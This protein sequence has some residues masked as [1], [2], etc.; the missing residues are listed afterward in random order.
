MWQIMIAFYLGLLLTSQVYGDSFEKERD[1]LIKRFDKLIVPEVESTIAKPGDNLQG[2]LAWNKS[3]YLA[4]IVEMLDATRDPK[5][6]ESFIK[7]GRWMADA[8]DDQHGRRDVFRKRVVPAWGSTKYTKGK[9]YAYAVHTGV[10]AAPMARFAAIV[11]ADESLSKR[12]RH[13]ADRFFEVARQAA[14]VHENQRREGPNAG[15]GYLFGLFVE[16]C[17]PLNQ[18]NAL[19]CVWAYL[20]DAVEVKQYGEWTLRLAHFLKN[21]LRKTEDGAYVWSY[22][23]TPDGQFKGF[24]DVSHAAINV[25]FMVMCFERRILFT[26][27]DMVCLEKTLLT[28]ILRDDHSAADT[29]GGTGDTGKYTAGVLR[30]GRLAKYRKSV[31]DRLLKFYRAG[32]FDN[33]HSEAL[34]IAYLVSAMGSERVEPFKVK[35]ELKYKYRLVNVLVKSVPELLATYD[36]GTGRFGK[37]IWICTDQNRMYPLAVAYAYSSPNN[38]Y[39]K[40]SKLLDVIM[41]AGDALIDDADERGQWVFRKKDGSTWGSIWMPWTYSRWVRSYLLIGD[42]MPANRRE[43]WIKALRL[44]YTGIS[45][46]QLKHVH[47]I[48]AHHAMGLY[49]AGKAL[50]RPDWCEQASAFFG[51]VIDSQADGGYWS[52]NVGPVVGY[53]FV[54]LDVLGTYYAM[55]GDERALAGLKKG[56]RFHYHF[57]YPNG[58]RVET[59]DERNPY[60]AGIDTGNVGFT[61]TS[62]GRAYLAEQWARYGWD[63]LNPDLIASL[64]L[65]GHEG[66]I[67]NLQSEDSDQLFVL[68]ERRSNKAATIRHGPWFVCLS[69]Y[70]APISKSRWIQ[71][72]QNLV[73][74]YHDRV[75]VILGGGNTKLQPA[76]SNFTVGDTNLLHHKPGDT[77]PNFLP[78]GELYH[79]P[80]SATLICESGQGLDLTYGPQTCR[81]RIKPQDKLTLDYIIEAKLDSDLPVLAHLTLLPR[82]GKMLRTAGGQE[83]VL[84]QSPV[85]LSA[86][87]V[88][89]SITHAGYRLHLP[90]T[91]TVHWPALPHNPY[92]KDGRATAGEGRIEIRI[93]FDKQITT[94]KVT[95]EI[96]K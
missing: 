11:R 84:G 96:L 38:P 51:K 12:F 31:R 20:D 63:K 61:F 78:A 86:H 29:V 87:K 6:A 81:I 14:A 58:S 85:D 69:A 5:Y 47:N 28:K 66:D 72:R 57:R 19:A 76:W 18:Q 56:A 53:N 93:P 35:T 90:K 23:P 45:R 22:W 50:D 82:L 24:E 52:E 68:A 2:K 4:A 1:R 92:R 75:G 26:L 25:D 8:R 59:I 40:D 13:E 39:H 21:R 71:D 17:L 55:S 62:I 9:H 60:K 7:L 46:T 37:G 34:G 43:A 88:A 89:G 65:Y 16:K 77:K 3:Y 79:V 41:K 36:A 64:L 73:S 54:Y 91:A 33:S 10:I 94:H 44:A 74:I 32:N 95:V 80:S 67:P 27:E 42:D 70:T 49:L 30:W 15:E 48:P 83:V